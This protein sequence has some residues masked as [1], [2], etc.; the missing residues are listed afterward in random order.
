MKWTVRKSEEDR[1][2]NFVLKLMG[3]PTIWQGKKERGGNPAVSRSSGLSYH[4]D[5]VDLIVIRGATR[6]E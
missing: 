3:L 1:S 2:V 4:A 6:P 5:V